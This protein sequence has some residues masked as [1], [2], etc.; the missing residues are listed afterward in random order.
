L[1]RLSILASS[2]CDCFSAPARSCSALCSS[3]TIV[4]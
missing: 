1:P 3:C 2:V 4:Q